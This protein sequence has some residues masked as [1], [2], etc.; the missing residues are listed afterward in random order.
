MT[1]ASRDFVDHELVGDAAQGGA[2]GQRREPAGP[3]DRRGLRMADDRLGR[4]DRARRGKP[5]HPRGDVH[6]LPEI[7]LA[8][9]E[10]DGEA[11]PLVNAYLEQQVAV[12][13]AASPMVLTTAPA[14]AAMISLSTRKCARTSS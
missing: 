7:V 5:L 13:V 2:F 1:P 14:S 10:R 12:A 9:V 4:E 11:R 3:K 8:V 6:G